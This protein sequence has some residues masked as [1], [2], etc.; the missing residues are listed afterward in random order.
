MEEHLKV[1][2]ARRLG[3]G[4]TPESLPKRYVVMY[5]ELA[6]KWH[7]ML[8]NSDPPQAQWPIVALLTEHVRELE[9]R[10]EMI[11]R[12]IHAAPAAMPK[13]DGRTKEARAIRDAQNVGA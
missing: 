2:F 6:E 13:M 3:F 1:E 7:Q 9:D 10:I 11:E 4:Q 5:D 8:R 12:A